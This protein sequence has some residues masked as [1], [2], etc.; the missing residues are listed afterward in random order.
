MPGV[1][2]RD[3]PIAAGSMT[4]S[5]RRTRWKMKSLQR[6]DKNHLTDILELAACRRVLRDKMNCALSFGNR[7]SGLL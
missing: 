7:F 5:R 4:E 1:T 6:E 3:I 2:G